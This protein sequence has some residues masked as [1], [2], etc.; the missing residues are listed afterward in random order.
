MIYFLKLC[1]NYS[2]N[3]MY[4][5]KA[6]LWKSTPQLQFPPGQKP[7]MEEKSFPASTDEIGL[8]PF[9]PDMIPSP[10]H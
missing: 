1:E 4:L 6:G 2:R 3:Y 10:C 7:L 9:L 8:Q 5:K